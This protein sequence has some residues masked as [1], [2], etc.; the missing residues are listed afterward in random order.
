MIKSF[1]Q[2]ETSESISSRAHTVAYVASSGR[3]FTF[4]LGGN[5]QL[6]TGSYTKQ[7]T[8]AL[9]SGPF[10]YSTMRKSSAAQISRSTSSTDQKQQQHT[11]LKSFSGGDTCF[12]IAT[13]INVNAG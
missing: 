1:V 7:V 8:P 2:S 9:I 10:I 4:G 5:G 12:V 6:G 3:M 13:E 11:L